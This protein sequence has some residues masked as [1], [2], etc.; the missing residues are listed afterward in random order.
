MQSDINLFQIFEVFVGAWIEYEINRM[1]EP[2]KTSLQI[3]L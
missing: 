1:N 3:L 2:E